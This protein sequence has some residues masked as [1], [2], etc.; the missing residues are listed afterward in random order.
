MRN[1]FVSIQLEILCKAKLDAISLFNTKQNH[2]GYVNEVPTMTYR[3][4]YRGIPNKQKWP[5]AGAPPLDV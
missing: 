1:L 5:S 2:F 4:A 3:K